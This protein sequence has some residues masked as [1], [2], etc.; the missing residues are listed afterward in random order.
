MLERSPEDIVCGRSLMMA[1]AARS[2]WSVSW[3]LGQVAVVLGKVPVVL[4]PPP[5]GYGVEG[6]LELL[7]LLLPLCSDMLDTCWHKAKKSVYVVD[8]KM[9]QIIVKQDASRLPSVRIHVVAALTLMHI[10]FGIIS[11]HLLQCTDRYAKYTWQQYISIQCYSYLLWTSLLNLCQTPLAYGLLAAVS[12]WHTR[13]QL[14]ITIY[15]QK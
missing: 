12:F 4:P 9:R 14:M 10:T 3:R 8:S 13:W 1:E 5:A 6:V 11:N 2:N 7:P 15:L